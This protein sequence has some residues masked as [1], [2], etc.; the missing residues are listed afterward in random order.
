MKEWLCKTRYLAVLPSNIQ[1]PG[2]FLEA[3]ILPQNYASGMCNT[4]LRNLSSL[5]SPKSVEEIFLNYYGKEK[6]KGYFF[7]AEIAI[8]A[9]KLTI[10]LSS[11]I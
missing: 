6:E 1:T 9:T 7:Q 8:D 11:P 2:L 5:A 3:E 10:G 4:N